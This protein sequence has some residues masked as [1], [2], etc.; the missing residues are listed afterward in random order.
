MKE[1]SK[2]Y[3]PSLAGRAGAL[4]GG[5]SGGTAVDE[6][7]ACT[8]LIDALKVDDE[9]AWFVFGEGEDLCTKESHDMVGDDLPGLCLEVGV[10]D[11]ESFV[12]PGHLRA[13]EFDRNEPL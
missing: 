5:Q 8:L 10:V 11:A 6:C 12:E 13:D 9:C 3:S 1:Q 4:G 7:C 2:S